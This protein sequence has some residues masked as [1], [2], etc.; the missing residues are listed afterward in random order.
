MKRNLPKYIV[1]FL[2][3]FLAVLF[4]NRLFSSGGSGS[5]MAAKN[6][7]CLTAID[8]ISP[9][10]FLENKVLYW[11]DCE[12]V[13]SQNTS[14]DYIWRDSKDANQLTGSV[15]RTS[16]K[17]GD[18]ILANDLIRP[19]DSD[20]LSAVLKSGFRATAIRVDDVTGGAGLIR[21]G[22][23]VDVI[24][25]GKFNHG[26]NRSD[27]IATAKTLLSGV[28]VLAVN[29]DVVLQDST[30]SQQTS[31]SSSYSARDNKG[32]V[33]LEVAPKE[34]ELLSVAKTMGVLS[35]AL[36]ALDDGG[37][38]VERTQAGPTLASEIVSR[39]AG[40][41]ENAQTQ[42]PVVTL[43]GSGQGRHGNR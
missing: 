31:G 42:K 39:S 43:F 22:N 26:P 19:G 4:L 16:L 33:T 38:P 20:F 23:L 36:C 8:D 11:R 25:S 14:K 40:D 5:S 1:L 32:T 15:V 41:D 21:P 2:V 30:S 10:V 7:Q 18:Y 12:S 17:K 24:V 35:L 9:G 28:R 29:R 6:T 34:V 13:K 27:E 37:Q 3:F